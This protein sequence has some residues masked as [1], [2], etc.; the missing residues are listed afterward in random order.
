MK[1]TDLFSWNVSLAPTFHEIRP[2]ATLV[3]SATSWIYPHVGKLSCFEVS[4][5]RNSRTEVKSE[6]NFPGIR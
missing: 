2:T 6:S 1:G 5:V 4:I 3:A